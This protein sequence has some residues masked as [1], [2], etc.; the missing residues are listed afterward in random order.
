[1][2][3]ANVYQ[4]VREAVNMVNQFLFNIRILSVPKLTECFIFF[5]GECTA[6]E[7]CSCRRGYQLQNDQCAPICQRCVYLI[8]FFTVYQHFHIFPFMCR[9]CLHGRCVGPETCACEPG[10]TLDTSGIRC[11]AKCD[12]PCLNGNLIVAYFK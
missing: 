7:V 1:M 6:P 10:W 3:M 5:P 2:L 12:Q 8:V 9:G 4:N 11:E